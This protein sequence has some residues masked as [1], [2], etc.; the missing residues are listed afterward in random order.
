MK[1]RYIIAAALLLAGPVL[2]AQDASAIKSSYERQ[3]RMVGPAGVGV[4]TIL[5]RW[6]AAEPDSPEM[7][8]ARYNFWLAK[9]RSTQVLSLDKPKYLGGA[10]FLSLKDST[11]RDVFYYE[12]DVY[13]DETFGQ[14]MKAIDRAISLAPD[15]LGYRIDKI[16]GLILYEKDSP[17]MALQEI[18]KTIDLNK[19]RKQPWTLRGETV[20]DELFRQAIQEYC[21]TFYHYGTPSSYEAFRVISE[22]MSREYPKNTEYL[23]NLGSYWLVCQNNPRKAV[24]Y[25]EKVLKIN[26]DDY[27]AARNC[28]LT[29]RREKNVKLEKKYLPTLIRVTTDE[30]ERRG[31][32][33]RLEALEGK[34]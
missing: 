10:P 9:A 4:E 20:D 24:K 14:A 27:S 11:G 8:Q 26:P 19:T 18:L 7:L 13:D 33:A 5:D 17:D 2:M 21:F 29:A 1:L 6:E 16:N 31:Y 30:I 23:N 3:V 12:V 22:R 25:Y 34:K 15:D 32:E 28:V